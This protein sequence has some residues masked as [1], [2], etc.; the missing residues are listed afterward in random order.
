MHNK[1]H[2]DFISSAS[3]LS[4]LLRGSTAKS[5]TLG[6]NRHLGKS[7]AILPSTQPYATNLNGDSSKQA[8][9]ALIWTSRG[10]KP[11]H[12]ETLQAH[13]SKASRNAAS[14]HVK[15]IGNLKKKLALLTYFMYFHAF[16]YI[17]LIQGL[18]HISTYLK[19]NSMQNQNTNLR[20]YS[21]CT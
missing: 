10:K 21:K 13:M 16:F 17:W 18:F 20:K 19:E 5:R 6:P 4:A 3:Y 2:S 8:L 12:R 15:A 1:A 7:T 9:R 11:K 14:P